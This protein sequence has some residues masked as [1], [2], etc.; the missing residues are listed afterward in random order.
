MR[1]G[2]KDRGL[3]LNFLNS[4]SQRTLI[5]V[6]CVFPP[7]SLLD[8]H[9]VLPSEH[10]FVIKAFT[11]QESDSSRKMEL[12]VCM[13]QGRVKVYFGKA[14]K[15]REKENKSHKS[16]GGQ[17]TGLKILDPLQKGLLLACVYLMTLYSPIGFYFYSPITWFERGK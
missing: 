11:W 17:N 14:Y 2:G 15:E 5:V 7:L 16:S 8:D 6:L 1:C 12:C 3:P 13:L 4:N 10:N 9:L